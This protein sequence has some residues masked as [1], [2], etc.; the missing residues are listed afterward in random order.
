M[1]YQKV[2]D[3]IL[4]KIG[5]NTPK[6]LLHACCAPCSS[7]VLEYLSKY[8]EITLYYY[9]PN[10]HPELEYN[11]RIEELK[12]FISEFNGVNKIGLVEEEY[13][14]SE[15]FNEVKGLENLGERSKR[16]YNCYK[17]RMDKAALYAKNNNYDYFTTTLSISPYKVS[18]WINEIGRELEKK[19]N[20]NY[21]YA[22]F[23]KKNGYKRSLEL[24]KQY[25]L[26]RQDYCGCIYSKQEREIKI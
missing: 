11:R 21:L 24:S 8:F 20:I 5:N 1:N 10:I 16:C 12:K 26:Y 6:L 17:F 3:E 14:T 25:N 23:K 13:N 15:Y 2:L 18:N 9:N 7:Y 4:N 19:Y 22:D